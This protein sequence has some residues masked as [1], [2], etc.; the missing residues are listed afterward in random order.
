MGQMLGVELHHD[1]WMVLVR[2]WC[3]VS[4]TCCDYLR[5]CILHSV[6]HV[7]CYSSALHLLP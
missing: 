4:D 5:L 2:V 6:S 7:A 3:R 1:C